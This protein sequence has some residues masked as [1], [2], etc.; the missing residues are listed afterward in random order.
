[1]SATGPM[2]HIRPPGLGALGEKNND[3]VM[4]PRPNSDP[5]GAT[6]SS[7]I[8]GRMVREMTFHP[9]VMPNGITGWMLVR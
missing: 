1:M 4:S 7:P 8:T 5:T 6:P 2:P 3:C 9:S